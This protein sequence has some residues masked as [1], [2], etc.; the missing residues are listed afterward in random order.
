M[1]ERLSVSLIPAEEWVAR[2]KRKVEAGAEE[3][4][5]Q[6][7]DFFEGF[8]KGREVRFSTER[9]VAASK[10]L[11]EIRELGAEDVGKWLAFWCDVG[12]LEL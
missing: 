3:S 1:A 12:F 2:Y 5:F 9:V 11:R 8:V 7:L 6:L 4:A 10:S